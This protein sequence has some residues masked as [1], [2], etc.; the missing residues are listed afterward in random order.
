MCLPLYE[1]R[2][3]MPLNIVNTTS[4]GMWMFTAK[5]EWCF[6]H[7]S[8][9]F[10]HQVARVISRCFSPSKIYPVLSCCS[11]SCKGKLLWLYT[12]FLCS[13][14]NGCV[15]C[16]M[17]CNVMW[18]GLSYWEAHTDSNEIHVSKLWDIELVCCPAYP[19]HSERYCCDFHLIVVI[20][21]FLCHWRPDCNFFW[22]LLTL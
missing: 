13:V 3:W 4:T 10:K 7:F 12:I 18:Q 16:Y 19:W 21:W 22:H 2:K 8:L 20:F 15:Y 17:L 6:S 9:C 1:V 11:W 14:C 5:T